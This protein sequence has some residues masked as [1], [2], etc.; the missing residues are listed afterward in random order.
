VAAGSA[1]NP[2]TGMQTTAG[3]DTLRATANGDMIGQNP[4]LASIYNRGAAD[5]TDRV[6]AQFSQS[7]RYGSGAH[8]E[9]LGDSLG[10]LYSSIYAPAYMQ[11]RQNQLGAANSLAGYQ[12]N[13]LARGGSLFDSGLNRQLEATGL[14]GD[15][16]SMGNAQALAGAGTLDSLYS[17]G[18]RPADTMMNVG[19][20]YENLAGE[21]LGDAQARYDYDANA[22]RSNLS[23]LFDAMNGLPVSQT[24]TGTTTAPPQRR[25]A[26][27]GALGGAMGGAGLA[28]ALGQGIGLAA[29]AAN[30]FMWPLIGAGAL[31]GGLG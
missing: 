19:A 14:M 24:T 27:S 23:Y 28:G 11:E 18:L 12:A 20:Q 7:G 1:Q 30:P 21:Y 29:G 3:M 5:I 9:T 8:S 25:S 17:Y 2:F 16:W 22:S 4:H 31:L 6:N 26:L 10:G 13:D 15:I